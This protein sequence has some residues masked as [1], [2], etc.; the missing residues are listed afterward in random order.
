MEDAQ[1]LLKRLEMR[2]PLMRADALAALVRDARATNHLRIFSARPRIFSAISFGWQRFVFEG[3]WSDAGNC[4]CRAGD[5]ALQPGAAAWAV[6]PA[7]LGGHLRAAAAQPELRG[8]GAGAVP[9]GAGDGAGAERAGAGA[10]AVRRGRG[11]RYGGAA[12]RH[13]VRPHERHVQVERLGAQG[14]GGNG[15]DPAGG[16]AAGAIWQRPRLGGAGRG[17]GRRRWR[18]RRREA[19]QPAVGSDARAGGRGCGAGAGDGP[20]RTVRLARRHL[21]RRHRRGGPPGGGHPAD[22]RAHLR[23][24]AAPRGRQPRAAR[25][26]APAASRAARR[27]PAAIPPAGGSRARAAACC[28]GVDDRSAPSRGGA[29]LLRGGGRRSAGGGRGQPGRR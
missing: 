28:R 11:G 4:R 24:P 19:G 5:A 23:Q 25:P 22:Q 17:G 13:A 18:R 8:P 9:G 27:R 6:S 3:S 12:A 10:S 20:A 26:R 7:G 16:A 2:H 15:L 21:H 1:L 29:A 14:A